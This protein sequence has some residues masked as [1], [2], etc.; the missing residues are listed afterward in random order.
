M[1]EGDHTT[2]LGAVVGLVSVAGVYLATRLGI[3]TKRQ[4]QEAEERQ[5]AA[6]AEVEGRRDLYQAQAAHSASLRA[7]LD[8]QTRRL[9]DEVENNDQLRAVASEYRM[10]NLRLRAEVK[11]LAATVA[12]FRDAPERGSGGSER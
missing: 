7:E 5:E 3:V 4:R 11:R 12:E 9:H 6:S 2:V 10:E 1:S 8:A